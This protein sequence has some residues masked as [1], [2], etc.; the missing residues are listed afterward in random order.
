MELDF[1]YQI[2]DCSRPQTDT[3]TVASTYTL[4]TCLSFMR[5]PDS[6]KNRITPSYSTHVFILHSPFEI[7]VPHLMMFTLICCPG[8]LFPREQIKSLIKCCPSVWLTSCCQLFDRGLVFLHLGH[9]CFAIEFRICY[10]D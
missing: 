2:Y 3:N 10:S 6:K 7:N 9:V 5:F 1:K 4:M 8:N